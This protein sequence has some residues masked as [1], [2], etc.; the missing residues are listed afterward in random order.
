LEPADPGRRPPRREQPNL[1]EHAARKRQRPNHL[2]QLRLLDDQP[3]PRHQRNTHRLDLRPEHEQT[4]HHPLPGSVERHPRHRR[5]SRRHRRQHRLRIRIP[6]L[7]RQQQKRR[8]H[9]NQQ[10]PN[11]QR[12]PHQRLQRR[13]RR[14][15]PPRR[16]DHPPGHRQRQHQPR[17]PQPHPPLHRL[18]PRLRHLHPTPHR[19]PQNPHPP[20]P[21]PHPPLHQH[22]P[23]HQHHPRL[24]P[25]ALSPT[26]TD[27][28]ERR[29]PTG[30]VACDTAQR[31]ER[32]HDPERLP[33]IPA[34]SRRQGDPPAALTVRSRL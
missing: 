17:P 29:A 9:R 25:T 12:R 32:S 22:P 18:P 34:R 10:H 30:H 4:H 20:P 14:P 3:L 23:R 7:R 16:P 28:R 8:R 21:L 19:P 2:R 26:Q 1:D 15:L 13:R 24:R 31:R 5:P 27:P 33:D 6:R 11:R